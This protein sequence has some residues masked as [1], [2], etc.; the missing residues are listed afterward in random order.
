MVPSTMRNS[1]AIRPGRNQPSFRLTSGF[2]GDDEGEFE[3]AGT[4][5]GGW[6]VVYEDTNGTNDDKTSLHGRQENELWVPL[7]LEG[8]A[9]T[10]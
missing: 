9:T 1:N 5:D 7:P 8:A 2:F 4:S 10:T 3:V 6:V